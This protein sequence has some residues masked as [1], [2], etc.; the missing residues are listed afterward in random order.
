MVEEAA[1]PSAPEQFYGLFAGQIDQQAVMRF[2]NA[3]SIASRERA[4]HIHLLFQCSGGIVGDGI[5]LYNLF[6]A[7]PVDLTL[8]NVGSVCS[9][10]VIAYLGAKSRKTSKYG[11]FMIHKAYINP[12]IGTSDRLVAHAG[13]MALEDRRI[14]AIL[15][16]E[17]E[18][19]EEKWEQHK[20]ADVWLSADEAIKAKIADGYGE[21]APPVGTQVFN[22]WGNLP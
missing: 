16:D 18:I 17:T 6:R 12:I 2:H 22:V 5:S 10:G 19:G 9:I 14:E 3:F 13:H 20:Y 21:F 15:K 7:A 1:K 4:G 11:T 8:Y